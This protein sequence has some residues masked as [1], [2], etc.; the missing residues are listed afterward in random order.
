MAQ[1]EARKAHNLEVAGSSPAPAIAAETPGR[2]RP[3]VNGFEEAKTHNPPLEKAPFNQPTPANVETNFKFQISNL[4][5]AIRAEESGGNDYSVGDHNVSRGP[6]QISPA[7]WTDA[8]EFGGVRWNYH[9]LVW[10]PAYCE[11]IMLWYWGRWC[12][13]ALE[14][15]DLKTLARVHNG[16]PTGDRKQSTLDYWRRI[17]NRLQG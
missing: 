7:Y 17:K 13:A 10:S 11:Q 9:E 2:R 1:L 16:G 12:P 15:A 8:C 3:V 4:L 6:Y 14:A 5:R